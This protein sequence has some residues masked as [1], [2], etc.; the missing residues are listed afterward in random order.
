MAASFLRRFSRPL[1][2][3]LLGGLTILLLL[4]LGDI[5]LSLETLRRIDPVYFLMGL[6]IHYSGFAVRGRRWQ[7]LL[8]GMGRAVGYRYATSLLIAGWFIS[9]LVPARAGDL[10]RVYML[11][12]DHDVS[13]AEGVASIATERALDILAI[14]LLALLAAVWALAGRTPAW[15]WQTLAAGVIGLMIGG[16]ILLLS[17]RLETWLKSL[18]RWSLYQRGLDFGF[19]LLGHIRRLGQS[20]VLLVGLGMQSL[21]IWLCDILLMFFAL[22]SVSGAGELSIAAVA[23]MLADLAAAVPLVPG[24]MGQFEAAALFTFSLFNISPDIASLTLLINRFISFWT[25]IIFSGLVTY[26]FGFSQALQLGRLRNEEG[27]QS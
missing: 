7:Q 8:G 18:F 26:V 25:F 6:A 20:P 15:V 10:A 19:A 23:A 27:V 17:P 22:R 21:Y 16:L 12:R 11:R 2:I 13:V 1:I 9:A 5:D 3:L 14:L 24:A 4:R